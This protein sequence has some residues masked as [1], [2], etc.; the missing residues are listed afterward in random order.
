MS[1]LSVEWSQWG[2]RCKSRGLKLITTSRCAPRGLHVLKEFSAANSQRLRECLLRWDFWL[3]LK[4]HKM[5]QRLRGVRRLWQLLRPPPRGPLLSG[6]V[7]PGWPCLGV[8]APTFW[9]SKR[10]LRLDQGR[11]IFSTFTN[12]KYTVF[13]P[14]RNALRELAN[15]RAVTKW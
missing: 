3:L 2:E 15:L 6:F 13:T 7:L 1:L 4:H 10:W 5:R 9:E 14:K 12:V 11:D 8:H